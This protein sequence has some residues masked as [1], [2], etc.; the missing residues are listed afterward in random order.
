MIRGSTLSRPINRKF[1]MTNLTRKV[2]PASLTTDED[3]PE[4]DLVNIKYLKYGII[5]I[6]LVFIIPIMLAN[7]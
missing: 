7:N 6:G 5:S 1:R 4:K 3:L 2:K